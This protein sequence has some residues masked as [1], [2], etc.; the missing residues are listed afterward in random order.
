MNSY[1]NLQSARTVSKSKNSDYEHISDASDISIYIWDVRIK[2]YFR[3]MTP[4]IRYTLL[5]SSSVI[6]DDRMIA[7]ISN[8]DFVW[9]SKQV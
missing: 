9:K 4:V 7:G 8:H 6:T 2:G 3:N 1:Y 5:D